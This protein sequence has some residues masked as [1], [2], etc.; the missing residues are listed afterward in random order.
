MPAPN[1]KA[2]RETLKALVKVKLDELI[3]QERKAYE[4]MYANE[5]K[6]SKAI[7]V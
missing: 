2:D 4:A 7:D 3:K 1:N 6:G 5:A